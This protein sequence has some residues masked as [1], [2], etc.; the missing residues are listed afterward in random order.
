MQP[1][2]YDKANKKRKKEKFVQEQ[3]HIE[4][5]PLEPLPTEEAKDKKTER[6]VVIIQL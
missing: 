4:E 1:F 6:G 3:L 5:Y 2:M